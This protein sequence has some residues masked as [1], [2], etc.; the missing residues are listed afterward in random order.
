MNF[1]FSIHRNRTDPDKLTTNEHNINWLCCKGLNISNCNQLLRNV[2]NWYLEQRCSLHLSIFKH[3]QKVL[4][5]N[6][7][8]LHT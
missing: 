3:V 5:L 1:L 2:Q 4:T 8:K 7:Y 6:T